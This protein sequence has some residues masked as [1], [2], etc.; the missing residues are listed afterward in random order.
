M[1]RTMPGLTGPGRLPIRDEARRGRHW[2]GATIGTGDGGER[3]GRSTFRR[4]A[5][6]AGRRLPDLLSAP[7][8]PAP[9]D[10]SRH[11]IRPTSPSKAVPKEA[12][13]SG[14]GRI[15]TAGRGYR[16]GEP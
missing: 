10:A 13:P 5:L 2:P 7:G 8:T 1:T 15:S 4:T 9:I 11:G 12:T 3:D 14:P 6:H 16:D